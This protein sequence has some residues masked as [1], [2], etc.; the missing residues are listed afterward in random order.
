V[1]VVSAAAA[2][3]GPLLDHLGSTLVAGVDVCLVDGF[4]GLDGDVVWVESR[5]P[6][7]VEASRSVLDAAARGALVGGGDAAL[8]GARAR[9]VP[10]TAPRFPAVPPELRGLQDLLARLLRAVE[11]SQIPVLFGRNDTAAVE[12]PGADALVE[13]DAGAWCARVPL[14]RGE[15]LWLGLLP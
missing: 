7:D 10:W 8:R 12:K 14:G 3:P 13:G 6:V 11:P 5:G 2:D 4:E 15:A 9:R 1:R